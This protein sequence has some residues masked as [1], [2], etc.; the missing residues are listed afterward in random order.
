M[1]SRYVVT[2]YFLDED[3]PQLETLASSGWYVNKPFP[4]EGD[5]MTRISVIHE[6]LAGYIAE[7]LGKGERPVSIAGDCCTAIGV[8]AGLQRKNIAPVLI[9][10]DAHGD[11]NTW[12]TTPSGFLGGM[13]LAMIVGRGD[14][15]LVDA[16]GLKNIPEGMVILAGA[17]DL[18]PGEKAA[19][20]D[21]T[22][23]VV[24]DP[25][26]LPDYSIPDGPLYVHFDT[27]VVDP[28]DA[29]AM[30]YP[31]EG[32][33]SAGELREVFRFLSET[34]RIAA[35]SLSSWNPDMEGVDQSRRICMDLLKTLVNEN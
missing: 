16:V 21:S 5:Q 13:P 10:F 26:S 1:N 25:R 33:P 11:F 30:G 28:R 18:D 12:E 7:V 31:A 9:W 6:S 15:R 35:V 22:I 20:E 29:P 24:P 14:Q 2:P 34:G 17:R 4:G 8:L 27:D 19:I 23:H 32:G 3:L